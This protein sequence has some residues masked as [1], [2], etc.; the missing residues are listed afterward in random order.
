MGIFRFKNRICLLLW[1]YTWSLGANVRSLA[2]FAVSP[3]DRFPNIAGNGSGKS[4]FSKIKNSEN[5]KTACLGPFHMLLLLCCQNTCRSGG[6][7]RRAGLKIQSPSGRAGSIPAFGT[8]KPSR[9]IVRVFIFLSLLNLLDAHNSVIYC[10]NDV[11]RP[12]ACLSLSRVKWRV[13][14]SFT[15]IWTNEKTVLNSMST[16]SLYT[17]ILVT[18]LF[19]ISLIF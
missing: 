1:Y 3:K 9:E 6:T 15:G 2:C 7:G 5:V 14:K 18:N 19:M 10:I 11:Y 17:V 8:S 12:L 16:R 4:P 13:S